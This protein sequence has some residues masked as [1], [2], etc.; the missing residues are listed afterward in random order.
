[1]YKKGHGE[2]YKTTHNHIMEKVVQSVESR[3]KII[4]SIF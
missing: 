3:S 1:M 4:K 2:F